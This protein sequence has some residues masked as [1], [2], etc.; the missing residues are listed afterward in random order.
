MNNKVFALCTLS[1]ALIVPGCGK[2]ESTKPATQVVEPA[3]ARK[4][5]SKEICVHDIIVTPA[6][7]VVAETAVAEVVTL[8]ETNEELTVL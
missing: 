5:I 8:T 4:N 7:E 2:Q 3:S 1:L 6:A